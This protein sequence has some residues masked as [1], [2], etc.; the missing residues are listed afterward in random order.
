MM[1]I[2]SY[3]LDLWA[4]LIYPISVELCIEDPDYSDDDNLD[5]DD[6]DDMLGRNDLE[7][8]NRWTRHYHRWSD[9]SDCFLF[10]T[11]QL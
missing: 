1:D 2:G 3:F 5:L 4:L 8:E 11:E 6:Y 9:T 7:N 10:S